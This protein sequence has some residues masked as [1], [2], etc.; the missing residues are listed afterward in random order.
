VSAN[1]TGDSPLKPRFGRAG[2]AGVRSIPAEDATLTASELLQRV[3]E[4]AEKLARAH[5]D[6]EALT[7]TVEAERMARAEVEAT[8]A[9]ERSKSRKL[10]TQVRRLSRTQNADAAG[11]EDLVEALERADALEQQLGQAWG[12]IEHLRIQL[13]WATRPLWRRLLRRRPKSH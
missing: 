4:L 9:K 5:A 13:A 11:A 7:S 10:G 6:V 2:D 1:P 3:E 8:L 12:Q